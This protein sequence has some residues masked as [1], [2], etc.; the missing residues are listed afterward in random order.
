MSSEQS[1]TE[2]SKVLIS[3]YSGLICGQELS[4][5]IRNVSSTESNTLPGLIRLLRQIE[6]GVEVDSVVVEEFDFVNVPRA[7]IVVELVLGQAL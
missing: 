5:S 1:P 6:R 7:V 2:Y 4:Y 3:S